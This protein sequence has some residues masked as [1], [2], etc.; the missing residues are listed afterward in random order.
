MAPE[1]KADEPRVAAAR[2]FLRSLNILLKS[3]RMYGMDHQ[4]TT[5]QYNTALNELRAAL[6]SDGKAG[7][8]LG[9]SGKQLLIDGAPVETSPA[10]KSFADLLSSGK[11]SS[12]YF[13]HQVAAEDFDRFVR[14]FV[15]SGN[16]NPQL[17][18]QLKSALEENPQ[19]TIRVNPIRYVASDGAHGDVPPGSSVVADTIGGAGG[20][21]ALVSAE[22]QSL[23][24]DPTKLLQMIAAAE[25]AGS[26]G[27][28]GEAGEGGGIPGGGGYGVGG[29]SGGGGGSGSGGGPGS[30]GSIGQGSGSGLG[31]FP[32]GAGGGAGEGAGSALGGASMG[33]GGTAY[34]SE[35]LELISASE[36]M[37]HAASGPPGLVVPGAGTSSESGTGTGAGSGAGAGPGTGAGLGT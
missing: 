8:T 11:L 31:G 4:R 33:S 19:A 28:S 34:S 3:A 15:A 24:G 30:G 25:G 29:G 37:V 35:P 23:L 36:A 6:P 9:V 16:K 7:L 18:E 27:G 14:T 13:A 2:A 22:I 21:G 10:E 5:A 17:A 1:S 32:G 12:I 26:G 20:V